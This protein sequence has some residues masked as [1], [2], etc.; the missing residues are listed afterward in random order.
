MF[1]MG[2]AKL[3]HKQWE[4]LKTA[5]LLGWKQ[6]KGWEGGVRETKNNN[7]CQI[8]QEKLVGKDFFSILRLLSVH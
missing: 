5:M 1:Q 3:M 7:A 8:K 4:T 6:G 2:S